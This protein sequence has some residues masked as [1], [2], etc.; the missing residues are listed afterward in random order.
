[1]H[2]IYSGSRIRISQ[3]RKEIQKDLPRV[4]MAR[5]RQGLL[6]T[7]VYHV[8]TTSSQTE[9]YL[10]WDKV[11]HICLVLTNNTESAVFINKHVGTLLF[12][13]VLRHKWASMLNGLL[14]DPLFT[15]PVLDS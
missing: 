3:M 8:P 13:G 2:S 7:F 4:T 6:W 14:A 12:L 1:M 9:K 10:A 5:K 11:F 15:S